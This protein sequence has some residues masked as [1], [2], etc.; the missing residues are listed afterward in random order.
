LKAV[1]GLK[2]IIV[3]S[4]LVLSIIG[5]SS[6][7]FLAARQAFLVARLEEKIALLRPETNPLRF[8][9]LSRSGETVS[10]RFSFHDM[11]GSQTAVFE[12]SWNGAELEVESIIVPVAGSFLVFPSRVF[13]D[14]TA[15]G[16][17]T[18]LFAYYD[19]DGFPT[20]FGS[21]RLDAQTRSALVELFTEVKAFGHSDPSRK[22]TLLANVFRLRSFA[23]NSVYDR[24]RLRGFELGAGYGLVA[25]RDGKIEIIRE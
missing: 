25:K 8:Q 19:Q 16:R 4:V 11:D 17:G 15:P 14:T 21:A 10:A 13:T 7:G 23:G 20:I 12:R 24:R 6:L 1:V 9:V 3:I 18:E 2:R 22:T 5:L